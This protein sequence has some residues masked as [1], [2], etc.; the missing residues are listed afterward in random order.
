MSCGIWPFPDFLSCFSV[1]IL[2]SIPEPRFCAPV[3]MSPYL[4]HTVT[5]ARIIL[6]TIILAHF[7]V[8]GA[9]EPKYPA[10]VSAILTYERLEYVD[11]IRMTL[12]SIPFIQPSRS[13]TRSQITCSY[14]DVEQIHMY[15]SLL[16]C[17]CSR[18]GR[19]SI[20]FFLNKS[21]LDAY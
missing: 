10:D 4:L 21:G 1:Y 19:F 12:C 11:G 16:P 5:Q 2:H 15:D 13:P 18:E 9:C 7:I 20:I 17:Y 8:R 3:Q 14:C 6:D